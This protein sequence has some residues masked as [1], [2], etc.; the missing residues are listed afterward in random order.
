MRR[1]SPRRPTANGCRTAARTTSS[2]SARSTR[3]DVGQCVAARP[4]LGF[5]LDTAH[6]GQESTPLVIDGVMYVTS[7]WSKLFAL[8]ARTGKQIWRFDPKVPGEAGVKACCDVV[9]SRRRGVERQDLHRHA[10][11]PADRARRGDRQTGLG[12]HDGSHRPELHHHRRAARVRRQGAH[13]QWR[14]RDRRARLRHRLRRG[15]RQ[16]GMALLHRA[17]RSR[18]ALR[19]RGAGEGRQ[20]LEGR[21]VEV[22]AAAARC[23]IPSS[24]TRSS[25][26]S[27]SASATAVRGTR[28]CAARA[29]ATTC[30][31]RPSS[32]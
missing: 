32:R 13:R 31:C 7:A 29:A 4:R 30:T 24:T 18:A 14:R 10:R 20:D 25:S 26:W 12:S 23:G 21:V 16:A 28:S 27:T 6:R 17:R 15:D 9:Q 5:D 8:D 3:I 1:A 2:V 19:K 22:T 11:R